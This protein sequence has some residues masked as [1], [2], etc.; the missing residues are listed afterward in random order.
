[1]SGEERILLAF[2]MSVFARELAKEGSGVSIPS[3][4][5]RGSRGNC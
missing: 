1:M 2:E 4:R 5:K 3:G